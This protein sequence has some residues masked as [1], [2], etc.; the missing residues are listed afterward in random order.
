MTT[1]IATRAPNLVL[2][3]L[4]ALGT[5]ALAATGFVAHA[6][7]RL[8][9]GAPLPLWPATGAVRGTIVCG[10]GL[11]LLGGS[12]APSARATLLTTIVAAG[13]LLLLLLEGAGHAAAVLAATSPRAARTMLGP[14]FW[15]AELCAALAIL[16][17]L[18]RLAAGPL[19]RIAVVA[20]VAVLVAALAAGGRLD[21]LSIAREYAARRGAFLFELTRHCELVL[22]ALAPALALGM[23]LG[24]LASRRAAARGPIFATLNIVQTIPSVALFGLLL[25]PLAALGLGGV[26]PVPAL[27]ALTLYSLLPIA[28]N[29]E[30]GLS[31]VDPAVT[32]AAAGMGMTRRQIFWRVEVPLGLPVFLAGVRI[33]TVQAIGLATVAALIGAGGLGTFVFQGIGQYAI[34][35]VLLGAVPTIL[36]ALA[37]DFAL[38]MLIACLRRRVP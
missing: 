32:D 37:A 1:G 28:R 33:V 3:L 25:A 15:V 24:A 29:T 14:G 8:V 7:N 6:P 11:L 30:A 34:D 26:G 35:L 20:A 12:F 21:A 36:L 19:L 38:A 9:S 31:G 2:L 22:G 4:L 23:P 13:A 17:A 16:D 27:I 10:I 18:Q 5:M